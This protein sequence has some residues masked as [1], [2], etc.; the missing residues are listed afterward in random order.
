M[1]H[2]PTPAW[3]CLELSF[4]S[5][6]FCLFSDVL[7]W[8]TGGWKRYVDSKQLRKSTYNPIHWHQT[9]WS[10][11]RTVDVIFCAPGQPFEVGKDTPQ[12]ALSDGKMCSQENVFSKQK[13]QQTLFVWSTVVWRIDFI[14]QKWK[15]I[16]IQIAEAVL[17]QPVL[18][19]TFGRSSE[20]STFS[21]IQQ[22][23]TIAGLE[24]PSRWSSHRCQVR[25]GQYSNSKVLRNSPPKK[26]HQQYSGFSCNI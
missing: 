19:R 7:F 4:H 12:G 5:H 9:T 2:K 25:L 20:N 16:E 11:V 24:V 18:S 13:H 6:S 8:L 23:P 1:S 21:N 17:C 26:K 15:S 22:H 10:T 14:I 3:E